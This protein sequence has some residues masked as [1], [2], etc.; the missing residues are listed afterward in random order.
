MKIQVNSEENNKLTKAELLG[1]IALI[2]FF[3]FFSFSIALKLDN[4]IIPD[5]PSHF[6]FSKHFATT[7]LIP[8]DTPETY[9]RGWFIAYNP[10]LYYWI[11][12]RV[13][14]LAQFIQRD[15]SDASLLRVLRL[16]SC[17]Y[18]LGMLVFLNKIACLIIPKKGWRLLP[19][20]LMINTLMFVF[21]SG[22]VNYDNLANLFSCIGIYFLMRVFS[23]KDPVKN[24]LIALIFIC[25]GC[26]VKFTITPLAFVMVLT[27][28]IFT[29]RKRKDVLSGRIKDVNTTILATILAILVLG[30]L[31][32]Y[33]HNLIFFGSITPRCEDILTKMQCATD[34][35]FLRAQE[36]SPTGPMSVLEAVRQGYPNPLSYLFDFWLKDMLV[37]IYGIAGH[38]VYIPAHIIPFYQLFYLAVLCLGFLKWKDESFQNWNLLFIVVFYVT[39]VFIKNYSSELAHTFH[40]YAIQGRYLFP[41]IGLIYVLVAYLLSQVSSKVTRYALLISTL[42]L[43]L[44]GGPLKFIKLYDPIFSSWVIH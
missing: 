32:I 29:I 36:V 43:F 6:L 33:G 9:S 31:Y 23:G 11:N 44:A 40:H 17:I 12:A 22:G 41:V 4:H 21:L 19:F 10:F 35:Y 28:V 30:N 2:A 5:E 26:L 14:N 38:K 25:L 24:I 8:A 34:P 3:S 20:F 37:K 7:F 1:L 42:A 13:I 39:V 15:I 27:S 16:L 18:T